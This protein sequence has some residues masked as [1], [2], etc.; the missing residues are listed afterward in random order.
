MTTRASGNF[1]VKM[2]PQ[3]P[4]DT[5]E[6][7]SLGR[8]SITKRFEGDLDATSKVE[9]LS[10]VTEV[11]GSAAYVAIERVTG[12]LHGRPGTFVLQ[13]SGTMRRG[14]A[15]LAVSVVPDSG[16]G[17]LRGLGGRMAFDI[18]DGTHSYRFDY[19]LDPVAE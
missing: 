1:Q 5:A 18:T 11:K 17:K 9:M 10:A 3:P 2:T 15:E 8:V 7:A 12:S 6:G 19:T 13:H 4:Y 16:T 14:K